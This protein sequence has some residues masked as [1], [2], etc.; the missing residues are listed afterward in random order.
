VFGV[1]DD[2][3]G[4]MV[5]AVV[6]LKAGSDARAAELIAHVRE[7]KGPVQ[8]PKH[9]HFITQLP[10]TSLGKIDKKLLRDAFS[11]GQTA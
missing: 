10:T 3:W 9:L 6:V 4:E 2:R 7:L 8:A 11:K 5:V 1:P